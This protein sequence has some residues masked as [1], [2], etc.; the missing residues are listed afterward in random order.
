MASAKAAEKRIEEVKKIRQQD[1]NKT[2]VNCGERVTPFTT[3]ITNTIPVA[4]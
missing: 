4:L 1:E 2:C 3:I